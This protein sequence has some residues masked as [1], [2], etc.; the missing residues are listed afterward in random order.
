MPPTPAGAGLEAAVVVQPPHD[1]VAV[2][3]EEGRRPGRPVSRAGQA[4]I[5]KWVG[6][7]LRDRVL[8]RVS[9]ARVTATNR[10]SGKVTGV[11]TVD[12]EAA[13]DSAAF[14]IARKIRRR[15]IPGIHPFRRVA[16]AMRSGRAAQIV[17]SVVARLARG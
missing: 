6:R 4:A 7:K 5:R 1:K 17:A 15:G 8:S 11:K 9:G 16:D 12:A 10:R 13:L 14:L 2:I 3:V